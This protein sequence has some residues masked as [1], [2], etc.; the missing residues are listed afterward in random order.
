MVDKKTMDQFCSFFNLS[1]NISVNNNDYDCVEEKRFT[2]LDFDEVSEDVSD[3]IKKIPKDKK[4]YEL[5]HKMTEK[6]EKIDVFDF[7]VIENVKE[8]NKE[9]TKKVEKN[10][11]ETKKVEENKEE[12]KK[13]EENKE[14][15]NFSISNDDYDEVKIINGEIKW[16][17]KSPSILYDIF[18]KQKKE[19]INEFLVGGQ[20]KFEKWLEELRNSHVNVSESTYDLKRI[21]TMMESIQMY[22][23]RVKEIQISCNSQ[24]YVWDRFIELL[25]GSLSRIHYEKPTIKQE[26]VYHQHMRDIEVYYLRLKSLNKTAE[27]VMKNLDAAFECLSRKVTIILSNKEL[28]RYV[29]VDSLKTQKTTTDDYDVLPSGVT[30][31]QEKKGIEK[32]KW[33]K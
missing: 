28:E 11:E 17:F 5:E 31:S 24:Y 10:K 14:E 4:G 30:V 2:Q 8:K 22:K 29:P 27:Q 20:I 33:G 19:L 7:D 6:N 26:G 13:V 21:Q 32:L 25:K 18:Y 1:N 15:D 3:I 23:E 12:T 9:E 16:L